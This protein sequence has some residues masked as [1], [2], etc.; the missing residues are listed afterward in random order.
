MLNDSVNDKNNATLTKSHECINAV[1]M[2]IKS[3]EISKKLKYAFLRKCKEKH[4]V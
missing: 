2:Q 1:L 3:P 4:A